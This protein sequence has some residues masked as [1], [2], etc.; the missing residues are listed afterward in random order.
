M[1]STGAAGIASPKVDLA[2][3][4]ARIKRLIALG[5]PAASQVTLEVGVFAL[6]TALAGRLDPVSSGAH[7]IALNI[8]SLAFMVPLGLASAAAVRVGYAFGAGDSPPG[9]ARGMDGAGDS[10][11]VIMTA[12][13]LV[14]FLWPVPLLRVFSA[15]PRIIDIGVEPAG[16]RRGVSAVRRH[17][18]GGDRRASRHLARRACR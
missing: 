11:C 1:A 2:L 17:A 6:A 10:V 18:G 14:F 3:D 15:D 16:H 5:F 7:Q 8:A 13:G 12:L 4:P 9:G